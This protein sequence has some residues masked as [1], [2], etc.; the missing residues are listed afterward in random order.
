M[1]STSARS[2]CLDASSRISFATSST[3]SGVFHCYISLCFWGLTECARRDYIEASRSFRYE[4]DHPSRRPVGFSATSL[5]D[6]LDK[7]LLWNKH[8]SRIDKL[9][10]ELGGALSDVRACERAR[11]DRPRPKSGG[12]DDS[13]YKPSQNE[14]RKAKDAASVSVFITGRI[15]A[16]RPVL[17]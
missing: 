17:C 16:Y 15:P 2:A 14:N 10:E 9:I 11:S 5:V 13:D 8:A 6:L 4:R 3:A 1:S 7:G 12:L